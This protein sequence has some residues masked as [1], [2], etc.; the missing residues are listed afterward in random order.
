MIVYEIIRGGK[1]KNEADKGG[2]RPP[3]DRNR[4]VD[5]RQYHTHQQDNSHQYGTG[6]QE[7]LNHLVKE[8]VLLVD[9]GKRHVFQIVQYRLE[10]SF[11]PSVMLKIQVP[12]G[13]I[14]FIEYQYRIKIIHEYA[15]TQQQGLQFLILT[16]SA[17]EGDIL[18]EP[19]KVK[20]HTAS[21]E[22][23]RET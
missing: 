9:N 4:E 18:L 6:H 2:Y 12:G 3:F 21:G 13:E 23:G 8:I 20:R 10:L 5:E 22:G 11:R 1:R 14:L 16:F 15:V 7:P 17:S 19:L